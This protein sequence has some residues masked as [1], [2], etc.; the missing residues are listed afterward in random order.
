MADLSHLRPAA[1]GAQ[2]SPVALSRRSFVGL[3]GAGLA[4]GVAPALAQGDAPPAAAK[5][6]LSDG[7]PLTP[8]AARRRSLA[9]GGR[10]LPAV[11]VGGSC[12][13]AV[14]QAFRCATGRPA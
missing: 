7:Q 13:G 1:S 9:R 6:G 14:A 4:A 3:V 10:A 11:A 2:A 8:P 12:P 5:N